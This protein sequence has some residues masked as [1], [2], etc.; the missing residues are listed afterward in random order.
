MNKENLE[1]RIRD[2]K[3]RQ[4]YYKLL[5]KDIKK[6]I[7]PEINN[8]VKI[9]CPNCDDISGIKKFKKG[10]FYFTQCEKCGTLYIN[11]RPQKSLLDT[12]YQ[13]S[14]ASNPLGPDIDVF[15]V[16]RG[17]SWNSDENSVRSSFR[18]GS[19]PSGTSD[20]LGFRCAVTAN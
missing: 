14:P 2:S 13:N 7:T 5:E 1:N 11:S 4:D 19:G 18:Y 17:G 16:Y 20:E 6:I 8:F 10:L 15:R 9:N 12:Y 3:M